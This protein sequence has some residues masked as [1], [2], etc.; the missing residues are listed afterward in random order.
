MAHQRGHAGKER[1]FA[2]VPARSAFLF[3]QF[4]METHSTADDGGEVPRNDEIEVPEQTTRDDR[5]E[6]L[7][8][9]A[10]ENAPGESDADE[11]V[12]LAARAKS[13]RLSPGDEERA[14][15]LLKQ[16][17]LDGKNGIARVL[18]SLSNFSWL[19]AVRGIETVWSELKPAA[20]TQFLKGLAD[21]ESEGARRIRLSLARALFKQDVQVALKIA[22]AVAKQMVKNGGETIS[23]SDAQI[24]SNVFIGK[25]KPWIAQL[26]LNDLKPV[27]A[28]AIVRCAIIATFA[29]PHPPPTQLGV[30]KW[31]NEAGRLEKV[32][33]AVM[34]CVIPVVSRWSAKWRTALLNEIQPLP[35]SIAAAVKREPA[36]PTGSRPEGSEQQ[37]HA[38][39][40]EIQQQSP[41]PEQSEARPQERKERPVYQPRPQKTGGGS[42]PRSTD[43]SRERERPVYQPR[44]GGGGT[45][46]ELNVSEVLRQV[47][48]HIAWLRA[49]LQS[50]Q[51][52]L[53]EETK[54]PRRGRASERVAEVTE[55]GATLEELTRTNLQLETRIAELQTRIDDL[56]ADAEDRAA[57][58]RTDTGETAASQDAQLRK[59]LALKLQESFA[60]FSAL[61]R[62][63]PSV[64]VQQHYRSLL[65]EVF[66]VLR[67]EGV[68]LEGL[69]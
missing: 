24:F 26:S 2:R 48:A 41:G 43:T 25:A 32:E 42:A 51:S 54:Q 31:T 30:L 64:V 44:S 53:R 3:G 34:Q 40:A 1:L 62:E 55:G 60:D 27:E 4:F 5:A 67:Q 52:K 57:S 11:L 14:I 17:M 8:R 7:S 35:E 37:E 68:H 19:V 66:S 59:L 18:E 63:S 13:T 20:R 69:P 45:A 58:M 39:E 61:E 50:A 49:E 22:A 56:L 28:D 38:S 9:T 23:G 29:V 65:Q 6:T 12:T 16:S 47:E 46:R 15:A 10:G 33:E 36:S 21:Q